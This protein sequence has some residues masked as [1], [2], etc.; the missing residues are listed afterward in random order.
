MGERLSTGIAFHDTALSKDGLAGL[1]TVLAVLI[2]SF[3]DFFR[4][5][6]L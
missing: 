2:C 5:L 3:R 6:G 4:G 1:V